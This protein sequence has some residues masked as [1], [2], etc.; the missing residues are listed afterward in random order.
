MA[1]ASRAVGPICA[2]VEAW[3]PRPSTVSS[4]EVVPF[5]VTPMTAD[6]R[7]RRPGTPRARP[8][9]PRRGRTTGVRRGVPAPRRRR[10]RRP[11][12]LLVAAEREPD[13][14]GG[15]EAV[16]EQA[17][18]GLADRRP[19]SPC[20]RGCRGP[21][22]APSTMSAPNGR[23]LP[24]RL[25]VDRDDV[26]VRHQHDRPVGGAPAPAE[27]Q[28]V[29]VHAGELEPLVEQREL[30]RELGEERVEGVGVDQRRVAVGDGG[31]AD[32]RLQLGH[33]PVRHGRTLAR[34][35]SEI[36]GGAWPLTRRRA[37]DGLRGC[38]PRSAPP[39]AVDDVVDDRVAGAG[40]RRARPRR[41]R[42]P[43]G[44]R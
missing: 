28:A 19:G 22:S 25:L 21:R 33:R 35:G 18:D 37:P 13:V 44:R 26:E 29:G 27:E 36:A 42:R 14:L 30:A 40:S 41:R 6:R 32:Q 23:V 3:P 12:D 16:L 11:G 34:L 38:Q 20:R 43:G 7:R 9:R 17:L 31:D 15:G 1:R 10:R 4:S 5:S 8:R 24:G 2:G 39:A